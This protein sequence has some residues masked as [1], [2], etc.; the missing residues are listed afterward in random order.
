MR[1]AVQI[2]GHCFLRGSRYSRPVPISPFFLPRRLC[3]FTNHVCPTFSRNPDA[4]HVSALR[5]GIGD[6]GPA[7]YEFVNWLAAA[8]QTLVAGSSHRPGG[9]GQLTVFLHLGIRRQRAHDQPR[10]PRRARLPR[11]V[12]SS[13]VRGI[14]WR[15]RFRERPRSQTAVAARRRRAIFCNPQRTTRASASTTFCAEN[16][17]WLDDYALFAVLREHYRRQCLGAC[18]PSKLPSASPSALAKLRAELEDLI[19][20]ESVP[21]VRILRTVALVARVLR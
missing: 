20:V 8:K 2:A 5:G 12:S 3:R 13:A 6:L 7:A 15:G 17:W 10:A 1:P 4:S 18:G 16:H 19:A 21:A 11:L 9:L 14:R